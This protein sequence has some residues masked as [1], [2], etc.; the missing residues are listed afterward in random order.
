MAIAISK[1][2]AKFI[3]NKSDT[4]RPNRGYRKAHASGFSGGLPPFFPFSRA[5]ALRSDFTEPPFLPKKAAA[6]FKAIYSAISKSQVSCF[7][8]KSSYQMYRIPV[9]SLLVDKTRISSKRPVGF[10]CR[11]KGE[12]LLRLT[13]R[14]L[15]DIL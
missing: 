15:S 8:R 4:P 13:N 2:Y 3:D 10:S 11:L 14:T 9:K 1:G 12:F 5:A 6:L 7:F